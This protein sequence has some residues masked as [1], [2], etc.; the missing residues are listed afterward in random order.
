MLR[1]LRLF[2]E[3]SHVKENFDGEIIL[4]VNH[5]AISNFSYFQINI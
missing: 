3:R 1:N 4:F 2:K 5:V